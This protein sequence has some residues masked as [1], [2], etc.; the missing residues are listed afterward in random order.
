MWSPTTKYAFDTCQK[1]QTFFSTN[2]V[3]LTKAY[4][5]LGYG[6]WRSCII[7]S[8]FFFCLWR[9]RLP[10]ASTARRHYREQN[11]HWRTIRK[12]TFW[13]MTGHTLILA[14]KCVWARFIFTF[15]WA[16]SYLKNWYS[17]NISRDM[18]TDSW[19]TEEGE[20]MQLDAECLFR[21]CR[22]NYIMF[23]GPKLS[24]F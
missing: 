9:R 6:A 19:Q 8:L 12:G 15:N 23:A 3:A 14:R 11:K 20:H 5:S 16:Y 17:S 22:V 7:I 21:Y 1:Y 2:F 10:S 13:W 4:S 24:V 18:T